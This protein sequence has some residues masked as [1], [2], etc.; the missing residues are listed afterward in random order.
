MLDI[1]EIYLFHN[2]NKNFY[3]SVNYF[4]TVCYCISGRYLTK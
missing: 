3:C 1:S 2:E 4:I